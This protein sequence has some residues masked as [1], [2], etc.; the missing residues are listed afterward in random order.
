MDT[1][2]EALHPSSQGHLRTRSLPWSAYSPLEIH[3]AQENEELQSSRERNMP[4][5]STQLSVVSVARNLLIS[6]RERVRES[7]CMCVL[8]G[9]ST[10]QMME[11]TQ[12]GK[13]GSTDPC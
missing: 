10:Y 11:R 2:E 13:N 1:T 12:R 4:K 9:V 5:N 6:E 7:V 3:Y 8:S